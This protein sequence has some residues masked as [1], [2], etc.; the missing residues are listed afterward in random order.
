MGKYT[1]AVKPIDQF[2]APWET[3]SG[4]DAEIEK[5]KLKRYI[6]NLVVDK[7]KAQDAREEA[8]ESVKTLEAQLE[9]AKTE[10]ANASGEEAS[11]KIAKLEKQLEEANGK[12]AGLEKAK[13]ISDLRAEVLEGVDPK[14]A[15]H[16]KGETREELEA[17]LAE[18]REDFG[19][20]APK[21]DEEDDDEPTVRTRPKSNLSNPLDAKSGKPGETEID[22]D[23]VA[24][25]ILG[26][27]PFG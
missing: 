19:L 16:V 21:D 13:E 2:V 18:I 10:A 24:D 22:Y 8:T 9:E 12:V 15:K 17:S 5:P 25:Q 4:S 27:G 11:K 20:E 3:E 14:H 23:K 6:H 1:D 7:A 26:T